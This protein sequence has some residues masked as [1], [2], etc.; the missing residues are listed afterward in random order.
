MLQAVDEVTELFPEDKEGTRKSLTDKLEAV[1]NE[2]QMGKIEAVFQDQVNEAEAVQD[3]SSSDDRENVK[4]DH[5]EQITTQ[6]EVEPAVKYQGPSADQINLLLST[7]KVDANLAQNNRKRTNSRKSDLEMKKGGS[8][9]DGTPL[10]IFEN[11]QFESLEST[12]KM[13]TWKRLNERELELSVANPPTNGFQQMILWTR[14]GKLWQFPINNEQGLEEEARVGFHEHIFMEP[15]INS[16]CPKRGPIRHFM[17]LV[18]VGLSKNP[19]LTVSQKKEHI[20][21]FQ[22]YFA[23]K[24]SILID[25]GAIVESTANRST[26]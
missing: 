11:V 12:P 7:L 8:L 10:K 5:S 2:T 16:W 15:H 21:W 3:L 4:T 19:Y 1:R 18:C 24:R 17:E 23:A 20:N 14:R 25:T 9:F 6:V 26:A 13:T 22:N